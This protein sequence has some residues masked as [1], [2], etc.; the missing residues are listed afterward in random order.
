MALS[1]SGVVSCQH[2]ATFR[3]AETYIKSHCGT[4]GARR[5][6]PGQPC[7][8]RQTKRRVAETAIQIAVDQLKLPVSISED[9]LSTHISTATQGEDFLDGTLPLMPIDFC[10]SSATSIS[11]PLTCG[12]R[13]ISWYRTSSNAISCRP[14]FV[15]TTRSWC[16][17]FTTSTSTI[18]RMR[19]D[20]RSKAVTLCT[21]ARKDTDSALDF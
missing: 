20:E 3:Y 15:R 4:H 17:V 18:E 16:R 13:L 5:R 12:R 11:G 6:K 8:L 1:I 14:R 2:D 7:T 21:T 9:D 19:R 10:P